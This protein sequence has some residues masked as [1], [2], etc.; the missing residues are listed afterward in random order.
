MSVM[1]PV[2][3][4]LLQLCGTS[5]DWHR[6]LVWHRSGQTRSTYRAISD[7]LTNAGK[8][9][10]SSTTV[11]ALLSGSARP[12]SSAL[13]CSTGAA[14]RLTG[15]AAGSPDAVSTGLSRPMMEI[16]DVDILVTFLRLATLPLCPGNLAP[17]RSGCHGALLDD[18]ITGSILMTLHG[19]FTTTPVPTA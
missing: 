5:F 3:Q 10:E 9:K 8:T 2:L 11:H 4:A 14:G 1:D 17:D 15:M 19:C 12:A 13:I 16:T 7:M 6:V 18:L